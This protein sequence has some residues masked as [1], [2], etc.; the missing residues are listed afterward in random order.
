MNYE[1]ITEEEAIRRGI[2]AEIEPWMEAL[3]ADVS[4]ILFAHAPLE[5]LPFRYVG[6]GEAAGLLVI[7]TAAREADGKRWMHV[8]MSRRKRLPSYDD[9]CLVKD[10]FVG[11][12][13][14]ALQV[15]ARKSQ[16]VNINPYVLHLWSCLDGDPTPDFRHAGQI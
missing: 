12:E 15:F 2:L 1:V 14:M 7:C 6:I 16:H 3:F 11:R 13:R 5:N 8:S 9:M 4:Q 10:V